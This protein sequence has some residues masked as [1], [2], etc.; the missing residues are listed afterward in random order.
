MFVK[1]IVAKILDRT[2]YSHPFLRTLRH[3]DQGYFAHFLLLPYAIF[4]SSR[5]DYGYYDLLQEVVAYACS[6]DPLFLHS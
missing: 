1:P 6:P 5:A 2:L 4:T 3:L